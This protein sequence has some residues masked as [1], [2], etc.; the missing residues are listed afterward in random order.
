MTPLHELLFSKCKG[1]SVVH[2]NLSVALDMCTSSNDLHPN[3]NLNVNF[4]AKF[5][6]IFCQLLS[7]NK[8]DLVMQFISSPTIV[9][10]LILFHLCFMSIISLPRCVLYLTD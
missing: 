4:G 6:C 9:S 5:H 3:L 2:K 1:M 10:I 8:L 7:I